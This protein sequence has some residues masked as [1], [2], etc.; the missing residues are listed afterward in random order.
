MFISWRERERERERENTLSP[1]MRTLQ[2][3]GLQLLLRASIARCTSRKSSST[4]W[5]LKS[6]VLLM[7]EITSSFLVFAGTTLAAAKE[8]WDFLE[9][10]IAKFTSCACKQF[11]TKTIKL[12]LTYI[13][14]GNVM[15][16]EVC[17]KRITSMQGMMLGTCQIYHKAKTKTFL[18]TFS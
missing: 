16:P 5:K 11:H 2:H 9:A 3:P 1:F 8:I 15:C 14:K 7:E 12:F 13:V 18:L 4:S 6:R 10:S 17:V